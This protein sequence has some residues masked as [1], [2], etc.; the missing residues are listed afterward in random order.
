MSKESGKSVVGVGRFVVEERVIFR[1]EKTAA[2]R[3]LKKIFL[4]C[5]LVK[6]QNLK[7]IPIR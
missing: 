6:K 4:F 2:R 1:E 7:K 5:H 3:A